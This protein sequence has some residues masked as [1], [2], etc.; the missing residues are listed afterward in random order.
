[1][2]AFYRKQKLDGKHR[3]ELENQMETILSMISKGENL[4]R[5]EEIKLVTDIFQFAEKRSVNRGIQKCASLLMR[6]WDSNIRINRSLSKIKKIKIEELI[7]SNK[8]VGS[9]I[10]EFKNL[11]GEQ[12]KI[13]EEEE[14]TPPLEKTIAKFWENVKNGIALLSREYESQK[15]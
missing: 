5:E 1:M 8:L 7:I 15:K 4:I 6:L 13:S 3:N 14:T 12:K 10:T 2:N 9:T 11:P